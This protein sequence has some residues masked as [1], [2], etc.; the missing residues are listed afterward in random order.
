MILLLFKSTHAVINAERICRENE[1]NVKTIPVPRSI[2]S[3]CGM[4]LEICK[5]DCKAI[6]KLIAQEKINVSIYEK[7]SKIKF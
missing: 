6:C 4:S 2:S 7:D 3:E 1:F 5:T